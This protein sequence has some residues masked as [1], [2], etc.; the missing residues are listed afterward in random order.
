MA[1]RLARSEPMVAFEL[2]MFF[3]RG[4]VAEFEGFKQLHNVIRFS[5]QCHIH[6]RSR[7][8]FQEVHNRKSMMCARTDTKPIIATIRKTTIP[9]HK[10][11]TM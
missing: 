8:G 2:A 7:V 9:S 5:H 1:S 6:C 3:V 4:H 11:Q 10:D